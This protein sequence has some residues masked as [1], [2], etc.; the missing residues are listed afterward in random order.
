MGEGRVSPD[1][2]GDGLMCGCSSGSSGDV[3]DGRG[4]SR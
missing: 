4:C 1:N 3:V 2:D